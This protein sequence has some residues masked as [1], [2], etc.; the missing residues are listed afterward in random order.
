MEA[1]GMVP[2]V[3]L[4]LFGGKAS[5]HV[6][7]I[8][9]AKVVFHPFM[10]HARLLE[11]LRDMG[12]MVSMDEGIKLADYLS[13]AG[14]IVAPRLPS[15]REILGKAG[16]YFQFGSPTSLALAIKEVASRPEL[17]KRLKA[18]ASLRSAK[19][20]WPHKAESLVS[21]LTLLSKG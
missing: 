19:F 21:F 7:R 14:A 20:L 15:T 2:G 9:M 3:E 5:H 11:E 17:F 1:V 6:E 13:L 16:Y 10:P 12:I 18:E 4:H 8:G